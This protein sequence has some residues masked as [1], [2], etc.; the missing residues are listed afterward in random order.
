MVAD[1][2][3]LTLLF[4]TLIFHSVAAVLSSTVDVAETHFFI[5]MV[6]LPRVVVDSVVVDGLHVEAVPDAA[7]TRAVAVVAVVAPI[8]STLQQAAV[9]VI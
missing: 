2:S 3:V 5:L 6:V 8:I 7:I 1:V 4:V 9:A